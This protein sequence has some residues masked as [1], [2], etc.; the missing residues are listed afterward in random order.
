MV[1]YDGY[2]YSPSKARK[3]A[4]SFWHDYNPYYKKNDKDC[5]N[6]V[7]QCL[8]AGGFSKMTDIWYHRVFYNN[9]LT[10][11]GRGSIV[12]AKISPAWGKAK[13]LKSWLCSHVRDNKVYSITKSSQLNS[14]GKKLSGK[15]RCSAVI[16][17][18]HKTYNKN[19]KKWISHWHAALS[20]QVKKMKNGNYNIYYYAHTSSKNGT[21]K[22][23]GVREYLN[24]K[25]KSQRVYFILL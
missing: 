1:D 11:N 24:K 12:F 9:Y 5:A 18:Y 7:S 13:K 22:Y 8:Y 20:G 10:S 19:K 23:S 4:D 14:I 25:H 16:F 21:S 17:F 15:K 3:Y 2:K 6:F